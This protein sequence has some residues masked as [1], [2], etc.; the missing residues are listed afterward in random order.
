MRHRRAGRVAE[1]EYVRKES[2]I[3]V[4]V[5]TDFSIHLDFVVVGVVALIVLAAYDQQETEGVW[6]I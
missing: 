5:A 4:D 3:L 2:G 6:R 1:S